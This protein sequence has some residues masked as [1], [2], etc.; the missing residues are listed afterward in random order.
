MSP[1]FL[2]T[3]CFLGRDVKTVLDNAMVAGKGQEMKGRG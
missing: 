1:L 2:L 3:S